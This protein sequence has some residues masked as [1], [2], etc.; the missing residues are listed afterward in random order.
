MSNQVARAVTRLYVAKQVLLAVLLSGLF[1]FSFSAVIHASVPDVGGN[2]TVVNPSGEGAVSVNEDA[3]QPESANIRLIVPTLSDPGGGTPNSIRIISVTGGVMQTGGGGSITL[4]ANGTVLSLSSS[5][6]DLRFKPDSN[7]DTNATFQ[8]VVVDPHDSAVNSS[9]STA[10]VPI[11]AVNDTPIF[12]TY[13]GGNGTGLAATY[14]LVEWDLTGS[15]YSRIDQ[16]VNFSNNFGVGGLN[17]EQFSVRWTGKVKAP[18]TGNVTFSTQSDDGVRLWVNGAMV[19]DNWTLHGTTTDT[20]APIALVAGELYDIRMEFYERGGGEVAILQWAYSGQSTQVIPQTYLYPAT[21]RPALKFING[22]S[23]VVIDDAQT[24]EDVDNTTIAS[25]TAEISAN[26]QASEDSLQF[27]DQNGITGSYS[28]GLLTLSG[29]ATVAQYQA[30]LRSI[31]YF[32]SNATPNTATRTVRFR[33]NDGQTDSNYITRNIEFSGSNNP[34]VIAQGTSVSVTMDEDATPSAFARTLDASDVDEHSITWSI[35]SQASHGTASVGEPGNSVAIYYTPTANYYGSDSFVVQASDGQGGIDTI[36]VNVTIT[37]RT[38]P[39]ITN[40]EIG[41]STSTSAAITWTTNEQ[42]S[43]RVSYGVTNQYGLNT[44][45][46]DTSPRVTQHSAALTGLL[47]CTKYHYRVTSTDATTNTA[48]STDGTFLT[49]GCPADAVPEVVEAASVTV[50]D[51]GTTQTTSEG[52]SITVQMPENATTEDSSLV[53]QIK[54]LPKSAVLAALGRPTQLPR[55]VGSV[56]FDVKAIINNDTILD[57]FDVPVTIAYEYSES[58]VAGL[59]TSTMWLYHYTGGSWQALDDCELDTTTRTITCTTPSFSVFALF[60]LPLRSGSSGSSGVANDMA[61]YDARPE[62]APELFQIT[63]SPDSAQIY[64]VPSKP[65]NRYIVYYGTDPD[66]SQHSAIFEYNK[67][68]GATS[69][70]VKELLPSKRYYFRIQAVNGCQYGDISA[71][72][73]TTTTATNTTVDPTQDFVS[74]VV[75]RGTLA[76]EALEQTTSPASAS[77]TASDTD[78]YDVA[79]VVKNNGVPVEGA[80][81]ELHSTPRKTVTD[82]EGIARFENVESGDHTVYLAYEGY[83]GKEYITL[84]GEDRQVDIAIAVSMQRNPWF[85]SKEAMGVI[86]ALLLVIGSLLFLLLRRKKEKK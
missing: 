5:R 68:D 21:L 71:T 73:A 30:A 65:A 85:F 63:A 78:G 61:C 81:V 13:V 70:L 48:H 64:F 50:S 24:I 46:T 11:T 86:V 26:Y 47:R 15:T 28:S 72:L 27:T 2:T 83:N 55:E 59:D 67:S 84:D 60:A 76:V 74:K 29:T 52:S 22:S 75:S 19:I 18:I 57:S 34:P 10:T 37:D 3:P 40:V 41:S 39:I 79:I 51:G 20:A 43:T 8:Y 45:E 9:E 49:T 54:A 82:S 17:P 56:V 44:S 42:A 77:A 32:N 7:R 12:Q 1:L 23:A 53:I 66:A 6:V 36:T 33:V 31:R 62:K 69:Y 14:Y 16:T 25:A 38:A 58:D 80:T 4:G 35:T